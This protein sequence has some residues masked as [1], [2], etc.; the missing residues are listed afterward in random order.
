MSQFEQHVR[1][2]TGLPLAT[3]EQVQPAAMVNVLYEE[4]LRESCPATP[5][6]VRS[7]GHAVTVHWYGKAPGRVGRKMGHITALAESPEAATTLALEKLAK[8]PDE[9]AEEKAA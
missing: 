7:A 2:V 6:S 5:K 4:S 9:K 8:L 3:I 1:A